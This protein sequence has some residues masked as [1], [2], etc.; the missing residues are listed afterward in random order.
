[1]FC[2]CLTW[3]GE[4]LFGSGEDSDASKI[5]TSEANLAERIRFLRFNE[6]SQN[7]RENQDIQQ[8]NAWSENVTDVLADITNHMFNAESALLSEETTQGQIISF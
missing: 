3:I 1:M 4:S 5:M 6:E 7:E 8:I 2:G